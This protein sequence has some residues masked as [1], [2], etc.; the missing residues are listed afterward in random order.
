[1]APRPPPE[2]PPPRSDAAIHYDLGL[3]YREM[4]LH[5]D[6]IGEFELAACDPDHTRTCYSMIGRIHRELGRDH[7][8]IDAFA[9]ALTAPPTT[10][11]EEVAIHYEIAD[12]YQKGGYLRLALG[13]FMKAAAIA[14]D[15]D[16]PRGAVAERIRALRPPL[17]PS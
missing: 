12:A 16:D 17:P 5:A 7:L 1:M 8:A 11:N 15:H 6:A 2:D 4:G 3:A 9:H 10:T 14:P 13:H